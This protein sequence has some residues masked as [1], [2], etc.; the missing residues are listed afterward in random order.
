M[1][2]TIIN[3]HI[4]PELKNEVEEI[5][6]Q[7]GLTTTQAITM[8]FEQI[9]LKQGIPFELNIPNDET[10]ASMEDAQANRDLQTTSI[11]QLRIQMIK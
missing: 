2:T 11:E 8:F 6:S 1:K 3:A 4:E 9:K 10:V 7:L 5:L